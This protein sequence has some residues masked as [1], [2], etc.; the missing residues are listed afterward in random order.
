[1]N[2]ASFLDGRVPPLGIIILGKATGNL[3][4]FDRA[5]PIAVRVERVN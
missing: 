2:G 5:S 3:S 4:I 1:M